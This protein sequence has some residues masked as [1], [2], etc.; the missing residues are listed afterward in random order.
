MPFKLFAERNTIA[1]F[2]KTLTQLVKTELTG[3]VFIPLEI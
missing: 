1:T 3:K 2:L